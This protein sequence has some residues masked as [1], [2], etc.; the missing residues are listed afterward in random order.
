MVLITHGH[1]YLTDC[2]DKT[3]YA[4][5]GNSAD[6]L[7]S[8]TL[9]VLHG[10]VFQIEGT[11]DAVA[12]EYV[13]YQADISALSISSTTYP[14]FLIRWKTS[15]SSLGLGLR[16][17]YTL[18]AGAIDEY[19]VGTTTVPEYS[20]SWKLTTGAITTGKTIDYVTFYADDYP[21][22]VASGT[23]QVYID[24]VLF[25]AGTFTFPNVAYGLDFT[26]PPRYA[27]IPIPSRVGDVTQNLGSESATVRV[28]CDLDI[29]NATNDWKRP[30]RTL[31][32]KTD[33]VNGEVFMEIAHLSSTEPWQWLDT[34]TEQFKVT[35]ENPV[36]RRM[37]KGHVLDLLFREKRVSDASNEYYYE[38]FGLNL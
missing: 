27:T 8:P 2:D 32:P 18:N 35:L 33:Y 23:H 37:G 10:D 26:P 5:T 31:S 3:D 13:Y 12:D 17:Y 30:Q 11:C 14:N 9:T 25:Y 19:M 20:S 15:A 29:D 22:S 34:G 7:G 21:N 1:G 24:F 38:R 6:P 16:A 28:S 4:T 36:F